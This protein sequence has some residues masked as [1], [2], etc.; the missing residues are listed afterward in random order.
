[1]LGLALT[2]RFHISPH[3]CPINSL[4]PDGVKFAVACL[5]LNVFNAPVCRFREGVGVSVVEVV[6][7]VLALSVHSRDNLLEILAQL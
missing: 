6:E 2:S 3:D 5:P 1:V 4:S 7:D